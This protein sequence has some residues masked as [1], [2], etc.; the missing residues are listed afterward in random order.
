MKSKM[1]FTPEDVEAGLMHELVDFL[2][3]FNLKS[4][5]HRVE[6]TFYTDGLYHVVEW[7]LFELDFEDE[8]EP[9]KETDAEEKTFDIDTLINELFEQ[10]HKKG[11]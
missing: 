8:E 5:D 6:A 4:E 10:M 2:I 9:E 3:D 1:L 7:E 11:E